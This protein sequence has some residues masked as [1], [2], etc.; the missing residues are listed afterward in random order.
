MG[1]Q[2]TYKINLYKS[3][4]IWGHCDHWEFEIDI[5]CCS[6][7][8]NI[9]ILFQHE[10]SKYITP[11]PWWWC[12]WFKKTTFLHHHTP[13]KNIEAMETELMMFFLTEGS[14]FSHFQNSCSSLVRSLK[15]LQTLEVQNP[16][17]TWWIGVENPLKSP[18]LRRCLWVQ[19]HTQLFG[20][21]G[22]GRISSAAHVGKFSL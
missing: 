21:L 8:A 17:N 11:H 10:A 4:I 19:I 16:P 13:K 15:L 6:K 7:E 3:W 18:G 14:C 2:S 1:C 20:S 12:G 5:L 9:L 22:K